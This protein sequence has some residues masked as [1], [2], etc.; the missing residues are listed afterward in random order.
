MIGKLLQKLSFILFLCLIVV[1]FAVGYGLGNQKE[2][3]ALQNIPGSVDFSIVS[4]VW[5]KLQE[6]Y[7]GQLDQEKMVYGAAKGVAESLGDPYTVFYDPQESNVFKE[8]IAGS[9]E[10]LGMEVGVKDSILTIVSP[11][12]GTPSKNAGL[13]PGDKIVK[14]GEEFTSDMTVD[15]AVSKMRGKSGTI[16]KLTIFREGWKETKEFEIT[17][18]VIN[19]PSVKL[20]ILDGN[21]AHLTIYQFND[22]LTA[23]FVSAANEIVSHG[24]TKIVL[25]LRN[26]PGGLLDKAQE[27]AGW[28]L[29]KGTLVLIEEYSDGV[30]KEYKATGN[31]YFANYPMVVLINEGTASASEILAA[32]LQENDSN[33]KLVGETTFGKGLVQEALE[34][35]NGSFLKVTIA[36]WLTPKGNE[37]NKIGLKP[38]VEVKNAEDAPEKD[39]QLE[40]AI[41][42]IKK[43]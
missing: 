31:A 14:I 40:K 7:F 12:E 23:Q 16:V 30:Q 41:E 8:S 42:L 26:N 5:S 39:L 37:I 22:N 27:I 34:I 25:D 38:D 6:K 18:A 2:K 28:F 43:Y 11:I 33:V 13:L 35:N 17:R 20:E 15:Q 29:E 4:D 32:S 3:I 36:R 9:F 21:I 19:I 10:G 1:A 24:A